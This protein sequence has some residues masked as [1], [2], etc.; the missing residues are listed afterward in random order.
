MVVLIMVFNPLFS[1]CLPF[2]M[3]VYYN[4][5]YK[6]RRCSKELKRFDSNSRARVVAHFS[7]SLSGVSVIKCF[8]K[9]NYVLQEHLKR[10][11]D[12]NKHAFMLR[13]CTR[14]L[15]QYVETI[16]CI[17]VFST[18]LTVTYT[19]DINAGNAGLSISYSLMM[20][21]L[22]NLLLQRFILV[23]NG[24]DSAFKVVDYCKTLPT[25]APYFQEL[26]KELELWPKC[27]EI[28]FEN[29]SLRYT[30][31]SPYVLMGLNIL[32]N[33]CSSLGVV[34]RTGAGKSSLMLA[35][36][37]L[38]EISEGAIYIDEQCIQ[39]IGL[40]KLR[41]TLSII[42]QESV[43]FQGTIRFNL[44]PFN[45]HNDYDIEQAIVKANLQNMV[46]ATNDGIYTMVKEG[47]SNFSIGQRGLISMA[48]ALLNKPKILIMDEATASMDIQTDEIIQHSIRTDFVNCTILTI[49]HRL[50]TVIDYDK[51]LVMSFGKVVEHD[52]P[53]KLI[54]NSNGHFAAMV[55]EMGE[56]N[57]NILRLK[58]LE[59]QARCK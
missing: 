39:N 44:D 56:A 43:L 38:V 41:T 30:K 32:I 29:V 25:E 19:S 14:W 52:T 15:G 36:Y 54:D 58:A 12:N 28:K 18:M 35:M 5:Q 57:S 50:N 27:G 40:H 42:P 6:Y 24:F 49:A 55:R 9:Q 33:G 26:D 51:I 11:N 59:K 37:R 34:G 22:L 17:T 46:S 45:N 1:L 2:I 47:G 8:H 13:S 4:G 16:A 31:D 20:S 53:I 48:R 7:E 3:I 10:I 21:Y 23:E